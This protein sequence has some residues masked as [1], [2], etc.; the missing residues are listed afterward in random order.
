MLKTTKS[1]KELRNIGNI[2]LKKRKKKKQFG[3]SSLGA[4]KNLQIPTFSAIEALNRLQKDFI[5]RQILKIH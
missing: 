1:Y 3:N 2:K 4:M 5:K